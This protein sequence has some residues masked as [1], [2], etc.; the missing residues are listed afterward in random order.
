MEINTWTKYLKNGYKI[1]NL[2]TYN[3]LNTV[4]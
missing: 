2:Y 4:D 1:I 3:I